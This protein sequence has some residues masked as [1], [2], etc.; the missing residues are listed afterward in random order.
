MQSGEFDIERETRSIEN[1]WKG[2]INTGRLNGCGRKFMYNFSDQAYW[3]YDI[4]E[5]K[6]GIAIE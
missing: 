4:N 1:G 6:I 5:K 2:I 3:A